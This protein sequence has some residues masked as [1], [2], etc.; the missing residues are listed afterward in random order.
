ME[1]ANL[2]GDELGEEGVAAGGENAGLAN[3]FAGSRE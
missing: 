3:R 2:A 1:Y